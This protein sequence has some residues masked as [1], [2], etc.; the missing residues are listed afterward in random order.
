MAPA[1]V[2][3]RARPSKHIAATTG[4]KSR[5]PP[6]EVTFLD[7]PSPTAGP[8]HVHVAA[9]RHTSPPSKA[10]K[11]GAGRR[12]R[13]SAADAPDGAF[14]AGSSPDPLAFSVSPEV[15]RGRKRKAAH[16]NEGVA[17]EAR[18]GL[19]AKGLAGVGTE[20][21]EGDEKKEGF[22]D[23]EKHD[24]W[25]DFAAERYEIVEQLPLEL[26]R[27]FRLLREL[28]DGCVCE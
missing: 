7:S 12:G 28:D 27:N 21:Q 9:G 14:G 4:R 18:E 23:E 22:T 26:H 2:T 11:T 17:D 19:D 5:A 13:H 10:S 8:S 20:G 6:A 25:L 1:Q 24:M 16:T 15:K 3:P